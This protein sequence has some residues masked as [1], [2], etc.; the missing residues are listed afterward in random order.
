MR[1]LGLGWE[2]DPCPQGAGGGGR[3]QTYSSSPTPSF[4]SERKVTGSLTAAV[5]NAP[6]SACLASLC[7]PPNL[8]E[9]KGPGLGLPPPHWIGQKSRE[10]P[11]QAD[12]APGAPRQ[13]PARQLPPQ[14]QPGRACTL[15]HEFIL[16]PCA[17]CQTLPCPTSP[18][19]GRFGEASGP[20]TGSILHALGSEWGSAGRGSGNDLQAEGTTCAKAQRPV[21]PTAVCGERAPDG[22]GVGSLGGQEAGEP[23]E[24]PVCPPS[25]ASLFGDS[26]CRGRGRACL[27]VCV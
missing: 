14:V 26:Q 6:G 15:L 7:L 4:G 27:E 2:L 3:T 10:A 1:A 12:I 17:R 19:L 5:P 16:E 18:N 9:G 11:R 21:I 22:Q 23:W 13:C 20:L 8:K 25:G 24:G